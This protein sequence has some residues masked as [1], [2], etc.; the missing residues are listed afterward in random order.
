G[1]QHTTFGLYVT[2]FVLTVL[3]IGGLRGAYDLGPRDA[4]RRAGVRR[5]AVLLGPGDKLID[6][7]RAL[8]LGRGGIDYEFLGA[9]TE[10]G[11]GLVLP[12]LGGLPELPP[13][14]EPLRPDELIISGVDVRDK[15][16]LDLVEHANRAGV[17]VRV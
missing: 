3:V 7:R 5:R 12:V 11:E 14:P 8:G 16:L 13:V 1:Y 2:A 10:D 9:I 6:L 15:E 17:K 4:W